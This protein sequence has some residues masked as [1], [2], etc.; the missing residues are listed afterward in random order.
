MTS[1]TIMLGYGLLGDLK[2]AELKR[3]PTPNVRSELALKGYSGSELHKRQRLHKPRS[4]LR[5]VR[6][7]LWWREYDTLVR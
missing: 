4:G 7:L 5:R 1:P 2:I 6:F 3:I